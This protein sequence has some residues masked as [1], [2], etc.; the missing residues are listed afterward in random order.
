MRAVGYCLYSLGLFAEAVA[1]SKSCI[2]PRQMADTASRALIDYEAQLQGG[3]L[4]AIERAAGSRTRY[5]ASAFDPA[6]ASQLTPRLKV[7]MNTFTPFQEIYI[8]WI[9]SEAPAARNKA[10]GLSV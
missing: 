6:Q 9:S 2:G 8:D 4:R 5:T 3:C 7:A 1:W 10:G